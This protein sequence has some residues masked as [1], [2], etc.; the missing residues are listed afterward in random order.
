MFAEQS[1]ATLLDKAGLRPVSVW[2]CGQDV[3]EVISRAASAMAGDGSEPRRSSNPR[4]RSAV[5]FGPV[6]YVELGD[7]VPSVYV[8]ESPFQLINAIEAR[9]QLGFENNHLVLTLGLGHSLESFRRLLDPGDWDAVHHLTLHSGPAGLE[10]PSTAVDK[11]RSLYHRAAARRPFHRLARALSPAGHLVL[12][13]YRRGSYHLRHFANTI[14]CADL[15]LIDDGTDAIEVNDERRAAARPDAANADAPSSSRWT[16]LRRRLRDSLVQW[17]AT[18]ATTVTF[19]S[20]YE[21]ATG[22]GDGLIRNDYRHLRSLASTGVVSEE[23]CFL[24]QCLVEDGWLG[25]DAYVDNLRR[26]RAQIAD[27][28]F[29]YVPH[30][31]ES[32][33]TVGRVQSAIGARIMPLDVPVEYYVARSG[34]RPRIMASFFC[35]A[36]LNC[37]AMFPGELRI[38]AFV[39]EPE[40]LGRWCGQASRIYRYFESVGGSDFQLRRI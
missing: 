2:T 9:Y 33:A 25:Q 36:L 12:G 22:H 18:E 19:F 1:I 32:A 6:S 27:S 5:L 30:P 21:L 4:T 37:H 16:R 38:N 23:A 3:Q 40:T 28:A 14:H 20:A 26:V 34:Y 31:R 10:N 8:V 15:Y 39:L 13:N 17:N 29:V 11:V 7:V 35:S 24:G